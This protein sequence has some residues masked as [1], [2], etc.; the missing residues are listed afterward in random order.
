MKVIILPEVT[1][2]FLEL[3]DI[4]YKKGY[5]G[6]EENSKKYVRELFKDIKTDL[7]N[8]QKRL[9][10]SYFDRYGEKMYYSTFRKNKQTQW[11]VFFSI[12]KNQREIV[13]VIRY[14]SNNHVS[15]QY[16]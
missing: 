12:Y 14:I 4:L 13:Y 15:A 6:F 7:P 3:A 9:A 10:P 2:Y 1:D 11:Y 8:R 5:F 16:L